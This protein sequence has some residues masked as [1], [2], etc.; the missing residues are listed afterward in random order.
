M[1]GLSFLERKLSSCPPPLAELHAALVQRGGGY[2]GTEK[3][4]LGRPSLDAAQQQRGRN[5]TQ[6]SVSHEPRRWQRGGRHKHAPRPQLGAMRCGVSSYVF[7]FFFPSLSSSC[8]VLLTLIR[9]P[10]P[11]GANDND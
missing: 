5:P 2:R 8:D 1:L 3:G 7:F 10:S 4:L 9:D 6:G 11:L